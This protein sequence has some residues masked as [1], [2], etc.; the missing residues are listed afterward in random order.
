MQQR[1]HAFNRLGDYAAALA[2]FEASLKQA[3]DN[4]GTKFF[5]ASLLATTPV[6]ADRDSRRALEYTEQLAALA[7]KQDGGQN[8][9][10]SILDI[11]ASAYAD[12]GEFGKAIES[13]EEAIELSHES[14]R[15]A[16]K[17]RLE[18][19]QGNKPF[20][21][22]ASAPATNAPAEKTAD[23][24]ASKSLTLHPLTTMAVALPPATSTMGKFVAGPHPK[25]GPTQPKALDLKLPLDSTWRLIPQPAVINLNGATTLGDAVK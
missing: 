6:D 18:L 2:D 24:G 5:V 11:Q 4:A 13:E 14:Q 25:V 12:L 8:W 9:L 16:M 15:E 22:E 17:S 20:R 10:A 19:Y 21:R 1:G 7:R 23:Q 3:P